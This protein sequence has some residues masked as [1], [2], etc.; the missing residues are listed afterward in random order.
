MY[1]RL[2]METR[3]PNGSGQIR[4]QQSKDRQKKMGSSQVGKW[5]HVDLDNIQDD[6]NVTYRKKNKLC[7]K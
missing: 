1:V 3:T 5:R 2:D 6:K 7:S 4:G